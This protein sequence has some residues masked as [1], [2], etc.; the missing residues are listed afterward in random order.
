[1][2]ERKR[3]LAKALTYRVFGS[4]GT[5]A[6]AYIATNDAKIGVSIGLMDSVAKIGFYYVHERLWYKVKWGVRA[7]STRRD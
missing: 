3:H 7:G 1:M 6:I 2:V 5:A 4:V